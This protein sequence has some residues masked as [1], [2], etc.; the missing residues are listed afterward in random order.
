MVCHSTAPGRLTFIN[1]LRSELSKHLERQICHPSQHAGRATYLMISLKSKNV[2]KYL[3]KVRKNKVMAYVVL[4]ESLP[5]FKVGAIFPYPLGF[6]STGYVIH[7]GS[8]VDRLY[9]GEFTCAN[10]V[11]LLN[12]L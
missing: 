2:N 4:L 10:I 6:L 8:Q 9:T 7:L 3:G 11:N 1:T 5:K 12:I